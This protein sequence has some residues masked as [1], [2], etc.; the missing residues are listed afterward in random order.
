MLKACTSVMRR[1]KPNPGASSFSRSAEGVASE[2]IVDVHAFHP[3]MELAVPLDHDRPPVPGVPTISDPRRNSTLIL[4]L[5]VAALGRTIVERAFL[6][7]CLV[8][9]TYSAAE[10]EHDHTGSLRVAGGVITYTIQHRADP[11]CASGEMQ[12]TTSRRIVSLR[13]KGE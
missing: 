12:A 5:T 3:I 1:Q 13:M 2:G 10:G 4:T 6:S 7:L 11:V 9:A 8:D